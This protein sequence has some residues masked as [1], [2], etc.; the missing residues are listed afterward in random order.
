[1]HNSVSAAA[2]ATDVVAHPPDEKKHKPHNQPTVDDVEF[3]WVPDRNLDKARRYLRRPYHP[4][5][6]VCKRR[7]QQVE[8]MEYA[9]LTD[10]EAA[11]R[12][13]ADWLY[14]G[15]VDIRKVQFKYVVR[16]K[17]LLIQYWKGILPKEVARMEKTHRMRSFTKRL[18]WKYNANRYQRHAHAVHWAVTNGH[19]TEEALATDDALLFSF[20]REFRMV[21]L[22]FEA[23]QRAVAPRQLHFYRYAVV[24]PECLA[25][26]KT[27]LRALGLH[28]LMKYEAR[29]RDIQ[30]WRLLA[31][32][33]P[34]ATGVRHMVAHCLFLPA[35]PQANAQLK[36]RMQRRL[37]RKT[38]SS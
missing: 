38:S 13:P 18:G 20:L 17:A 29:Q 7:L 14:A 4:P 10:E 5:G 15:H 3:V 25:K 19:V 34:R 28:I 27:G 37:A 24:V 2:A 11:A 6:F 33:C 32:R 23:Q 36:M 1:M 8:Q 31:G 30:N 9:S 16:T 12:M 26:K 35:M 21:E 22:A